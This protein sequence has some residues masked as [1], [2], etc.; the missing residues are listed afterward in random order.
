[1]VSKLCFFIALCVF[2][3]CK[4]ELFT[5]DM[6]CR[7]QL[8]KSKAIV[9]KSYRFYCSSTRLGS[10]YRRKHQ[11][12]FQFIALNTPDTPPI[13]QKNP[14]CKNTNTFVICLQHFI[15]NYLESSVLKFQINSVHNR[16]ATRFQIIA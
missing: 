11:F 8:H 2:F 5:I 15:D 7:I 14:T 12:H 9:I 16:V 10:K 1:M 13:T 6:F 4:F 3:F